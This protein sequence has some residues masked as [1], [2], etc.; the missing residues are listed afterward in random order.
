L[1]DWIVWLFL[2][3]EIAFLVLA[4][5]AGVGLLVWIIQVVLEMARI[6]KKPRNTTKNK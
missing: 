3:G 2:A 4:A 1:I 6:N 5:I